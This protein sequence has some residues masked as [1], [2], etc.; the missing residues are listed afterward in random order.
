MFRFEARECF[1]EDVGGVLICGT[2][3]QLDFPILYRVH[4]ETFELL[5][6]LDVFGNNY[7]IALPISV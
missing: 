2:V 6:C 7:T 1:G 5:T 3:D 4:Q